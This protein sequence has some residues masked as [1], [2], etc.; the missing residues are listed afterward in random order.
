MHVGLVAI[1]G[2][3]RRRHQ[4]NPGIGNDQRP[5]NPG[6]RNRGRI[7]SVCNGK[8]DLSDY[9]VGTTASNDIENSIIPILVVPQ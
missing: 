7:T 6:M 8:N 3:Q 4:H 1:V 2:D 5:N 9:L